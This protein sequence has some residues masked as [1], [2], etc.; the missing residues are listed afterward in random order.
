[1]KTIWT[2][3]KGNHIALVDDVV[4]GHIFKTASNPNTKAVYVWQASSFFVLHCG[5]RNHGESFRTL[6]G[7]K[8]W[9]TSR[10]K[11]AEK[12]RLTNFVSYDIHGM[13]E[14]IDKYFSK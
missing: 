9:I 14:H 10:A 1:M 4:I 13:E 3:Y 6:A 2:E 7:A 8:R 11:Q 5:L 12:D